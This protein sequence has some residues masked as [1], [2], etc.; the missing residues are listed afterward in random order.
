[1]L[2]L[3]GIEAV[4][5]GVDADV[6]VPP[7]TGSPAGGALLAPADAQEPATRLAAA[8]RMASRPNS[9]VF[10]RTDLICSPLSVIGST[11]PHA[12]SVDRTR[13]RFPK[14]F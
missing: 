5:L 7:G 4:G 14:R 8:P 1:M 2:P 6:I 10:V 13:N 12:A 9:P 3:P 11:S